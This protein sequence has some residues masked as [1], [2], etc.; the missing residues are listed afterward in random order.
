[1]V[2]IPLIVIE[3]K[4]TPNGNPSNDFYWRKKS[5][6]L[7]VVPVTE[8]NQNWKREILGPTGRASQS[9]T[10]A[11]FQEVP[12]FPFSVFDFLRLPG[13]YSIMIE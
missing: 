3:L 9:T 11:Q 10:P 6:S 2:I 7:N 13:Q 5:S 4:A 1:M 12:I 8:E